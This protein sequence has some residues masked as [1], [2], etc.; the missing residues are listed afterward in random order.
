M[1]YIEF[2]LFLPRVSCHCG[3]AAT[4]RGLPQIGSLRF[5]AQWELV[6]AHGP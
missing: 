3:F 6:M 5:T 2:L 4:L 1:F